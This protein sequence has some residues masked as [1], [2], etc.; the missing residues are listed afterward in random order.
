MY[1]EKNL[2]HEMVQFMDQYGSL[3]HDNIDLN[4]SQLLEIYNWMLKT[5]LF[6]E[7]MVRMQRQGRIGTYAP[8]SGQEASQVGSTYA[9]EK[10]DWIFSSYREIA[11]TMVHG[12]PM[13]QSILYAK[14]HMYGGQS[15]DKLNIFPIQII[16]AGQTLHAAGCALASKL[17]GE[18]DVSVS[19]F[20]DGATSEGDFHEAL[21]IASVFKVPSVFFCQNNHWAISVPLHQQTASQTIAQKAIAYGVK[22]VRVDGNDVLAV[23]HVMKEAL[24]SARNGEGPTLIE[25]V[26]YRQGPHTTADDPTKYRNNDEVNEWAK[27]DPIDRFR[28]FLNKRGLMD[29]DKQEKMKGIVNEEI[30]K[31]VAEA[32]STDR[33]T[34]DKAFDYVYDKPHKLLLEQQ[35]E[36]RQFLTIKEGR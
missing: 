32:E 18:N 22:G 26:T 5:R 35:E 8:F 1:D 13:Q 6:D 9:M 2:N 10:D 29:E 21:N 23:Y 14:G 36:S 3:L 27:K 20:G 34:V 19:Y 16:I 24:E 25:A 30:E 15:P 31:A 12:L 11:A 4:D 33:V 28:T 17:K 7:K